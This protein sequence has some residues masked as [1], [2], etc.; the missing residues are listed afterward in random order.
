MCVCVFVC[1]C[2]FGG[3]GGGGVREGGRARRSGAADEKGLPM[4]ALASTV[5]RGQTNF[6]S[7][8]LYVLY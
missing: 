3:G 1:V 2:V 7:M 8:Q 4:S 6:Y 5:V